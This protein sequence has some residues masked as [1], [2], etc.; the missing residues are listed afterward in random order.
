MFQLQNQY[1]IYVDLCQKGDVSY[2]KCNCKAGMGECC[3]DVAAVLFQ[4]NECKQ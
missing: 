2:A 1:L 3:K 4:L